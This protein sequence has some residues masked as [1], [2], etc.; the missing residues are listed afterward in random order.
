MIASVLF[1]GGLILM[2]LAT[3]G[4]RFQILFEQ[5][6]GRTEYFID[7]TNREPPHH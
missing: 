3:M 1:L 7:T 5:L 4:R 6:K 2:L